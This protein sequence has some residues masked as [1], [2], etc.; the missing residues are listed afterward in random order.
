MGLKQPH[1]APRNE[2]L[3]KLETQS[4]DQREMLMEIGAKAGRLLLWF[5]MMV[6]V[7]MFDRFGVTTSF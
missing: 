7:M 2:K 3:I 5:D 6:G 4:A 1:R